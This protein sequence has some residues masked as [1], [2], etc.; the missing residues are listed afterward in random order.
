MLKCFLITLYLFIVSACHTVQTWNKGYPKEGSELSTMSEKDK[1]FNKFAISDESTGRWSEWYL[2]MNED[3]DSDKYYSLRS[4]S[5]VVTRVSPQTLDKL[6]DLR[7]AKKYYSLTIGVLIASLFLKPGNLKP[8]NKSTE[9][10]SNILYASGL[11]GV[12]GISL[13]QLGIFN[14]IKYQYNSDLNTHIYGNPFGHQSSQKSSGIY[15]IR[16]TH[17]FH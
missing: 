8:G 5:P 7:T 12:V 6:Q 3:K 14:D 9:V 15:G 17:K 13:W 10:L 11:G 2:Q 1:E 4:F 16:I